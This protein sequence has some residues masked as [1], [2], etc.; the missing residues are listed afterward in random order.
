MKK[1]DSS[2]TIYDGLCETKYYNN[3]MD[4]AEIKIQLQKHQEAISL[5]TNSLLELKNESQLKSTQDKS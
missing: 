2:Q 3:P 1:S 4:L 5:L